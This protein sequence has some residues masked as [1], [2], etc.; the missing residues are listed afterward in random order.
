VDPKEFNTPEGRLR[1]QILRELFRAIGSHIGW[2]HTVS[3]WALGTTGVHIGL[4]ISNLDKIQLHLSDGWQ[5][6]IF[7]CT[8]ISAA[9]GIGIQIA[10]GL[11]QFGLSI[12][13]HLFP[14]L[15]NSFRA[16]RRAV[17]P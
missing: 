6:P 16:N 15:M 17:S 4:L 11:V 13:N 5:R 2:I 12:E 14:F 9:V 8:A 3:N 10:A 7:L 1:F